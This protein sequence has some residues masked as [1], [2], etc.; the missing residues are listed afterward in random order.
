MNYKTEK[1]N[2]FDILYIFKSLFLL[3]TTNVQ[4]I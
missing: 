1:K 4:N 3:S 2:N